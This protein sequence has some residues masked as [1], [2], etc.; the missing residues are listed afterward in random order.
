MKKIRKLT[1]FFFFISLLWVSFKG[2]S[3][4][5]QENFVVRI[6]ED[7]TFTEFNYHQAWF[8]DDPNNPLPWPEEREAISEGNTAYVF[9]KATP[10]HAG[11]AHAMV[12]VNFEWDLKDY[13]WEE[14]KNWPIEV[15][16]DFSYKIEAYWVEGNGSANAGVEVVGLE[17]SD[18][19]DF[20]GRETG[21]MGE[22]SREVSET[23][24]TTIEE[25]GNLV[26]L[27]A[28]SQ[29]HS[30]TSTVHYSSSKIVVKRIKIEFLTPPKIELLS[31][32]MVSPTEL[33]IAVKVWFP[34]TSENYSRFIKFN[35]T[36][37]GQPIEEEIDITGLIQL[38]EEVK[39]G[40]DPSGNLDPATPLKIDLK[41]W[42]VKRFT[43][44]EKF[45]LRAIAYFKDGPVSE[46]DEKEVKIL[47][48]TI[49]IH[50]L[51]AKPGGLLPIW[52]QRFLSRFLSFF[53]AYH[54]FMHYLQKETRGDFITGYDIEEGRYKTLWWFSYD[55][56]KGTPQGVAQKLDELITQQIIDPEKGMTY[57]A[58]VN[59]IGHSL[60]GLV[61]RY[62]TASWG[63]AEKVHRVIMIGAPNN[64][65]SK[66]YLA[67][68]G[69]S[70]ERVERCLTQMPFFGWF[71]PTYEALYDRYEDYPEH[72]LKPFIPNS[73]PRDP[74][75]KNVIYHNIYGTTQTTARALIV[76][77]KNG[78]YQVEKRETRK[79]WK[80]LSSPGDGTVPVEGARLLGGVINLPVKN[81]LSHASL[82]A[83]PIV[84]KVVLYDCLLQD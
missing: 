53:F 22:R 30:A 82:P 18:W 50:G 17:E 37:N 49:V 68:S 62:Y 29:A 4:L 16:I 43:K 80:E 31:A 41:K 54:N 20:I 60:G 6:G 69:W 79:H 3:V 58:K 28:C 48:P 23:Y 11:E 24:Q 1:L 71:I 2:V 47:L 81:V 73:F 61:A 19:Y 83:D 10:S 12:G 57:A 75:P 14:V 66:F 27:H 59:L 51:M 13:Q 70:R 15:T 35:A 8:E 33:G 77:V 67:S 34:E 38:G 36:I 39:I 56:I 74:L 72:P 21:E 46:P 65:S 40:I 64:G 52:L 5:A 26:L 84:K 32:K 25:L 9:L 44:N 42:K 55:S 63:G 7:K 78:W 45:I 76:E